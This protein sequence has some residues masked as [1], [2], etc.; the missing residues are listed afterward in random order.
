MVLLGLTAN[1]SIAKKFVKTAEGACYV[2]SEY[3]LF[4]WCIVPMFSD[5]SVALRSRFVI[6]VSENRN[7]RCTG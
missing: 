5:R 3:L 6:R 4:V 7:E 2:K 1:V